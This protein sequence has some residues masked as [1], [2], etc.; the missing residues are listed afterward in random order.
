[1]YHVRFCFTPPPPKILPNICHCPNEPNSIIEHT[2]DRLQIR[3]QELLLGIN[4]KEI[5]EIWEVNYIV[6]SSTSKSHYVVI[7][8]DMILLCT[9]IYIINQGILYRHQY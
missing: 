6:T 5:Q 3:L 8:K 7:L 1:L 4:H 2:Y 9:C